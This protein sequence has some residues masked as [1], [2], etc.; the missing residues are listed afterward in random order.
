MGRKPLEGEAARESIIKTIDKVARTVPVMGGKWKRNMLSHYY[1]RLAELTLLQRDDG[2]VT[3]G[4]VK[5]LAETY[6][7]LVEEGNELT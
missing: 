4:D 1:K 7:R 6:A 5:V 3:N 2:E